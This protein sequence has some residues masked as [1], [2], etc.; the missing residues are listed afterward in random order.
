M[1]WEAFHASIVLSTT[2]QAA[3]ALGLDGAVAHA[4]VAAENVEPLPQPRR[5]LGH[6][7][8]GQSLSLCRRGH[9]HA[10]RPTAEAWL[11]LW[12]RERAVLIAP[13]VRIRRICACCGPSRPLLSSDDMREALVALPASRDPHSALGLWRHVPDKALARDERR[14]VPDEAQTLR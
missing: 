13:A 11:H 4:Q 10:G 7:R 5:R 8:R 14:D 1:R 3:D 2:A 9:Y 12:L 6:A